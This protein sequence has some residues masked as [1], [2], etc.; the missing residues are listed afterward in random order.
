M[1]HSLTRLLSCQ[2]VHVSLVAFKVGQRPTREHGHS[3]V[4]ATLRMRCSRIVVLAANAPTASGKRCDTRLR[5][6]DNSMRAWPLAKRI[7]CATTCAWRIRSA[8][9]SARGPMDDALPRWTLQG[10][11]GDVDLAQQSV[12]VPGLVSSAFTAYQLA[13]DASE[14]LRRARALHH[15][16]LTSDSTVDLARCTWCCGPCA[17]VSLRSWPLPHRMNWPSTC[18]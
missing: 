10:A 4:T 18:A 6:L 9:S 5:S 7:L 17:A 1:H 14:A 11:P 13:R 3:N 16:R 15:A 2:M 12:C 8:A